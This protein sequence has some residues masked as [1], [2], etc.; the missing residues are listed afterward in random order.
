MV[1]LRPL[2]VVTGTLRVEGGLKRA[3]TK[4]KAKGSQIMVTESL[5]IGE[6]RRAGNVVAARYLRKLAGLKI[7][8]TP[9]GSLVDPKNLDRVKDTISQAMIDCQA[10]NR[11]HEKCKVM[12]TMIWEHLRGQRLDAI[13]AWVDR[14]VREGDDSV[15]AVLSSLIAEQAA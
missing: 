14:R 13:I 12:N 10:F 3:R 2:I 9:F 1:E 6:D 8:H 5:N 7:L 15:T 4:A 11:A